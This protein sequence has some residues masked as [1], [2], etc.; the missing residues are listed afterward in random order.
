MGD[1]MDA[2]AKDVNRLLGEL[3]K[4]SKALKKNPNDAK[5]LKQRKDLEPFLEAKALKRRQDKAAEM[6]LAAMGKTIKDC[7]LPWKL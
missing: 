4:I 7:G 1:Y 3:E 6:D 5:A 2:F